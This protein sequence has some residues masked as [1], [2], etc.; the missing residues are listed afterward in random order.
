MLVV[1][2]SGEIIVGAAATGSGR[3]S[4]ESAQHRAEADVPG[5][6]GLKRITLVRA[7][8]V[9]PYGRFKSVGDVEVQSLVL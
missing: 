1:T 7:M 8:A 4:A 5:V 6:E 2:D 3:R 9:F